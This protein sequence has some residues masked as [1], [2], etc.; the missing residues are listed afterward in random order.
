VYR[1]REKRRRRLVEIIEKFRQKGAISPEK[2]MSIQE[3]G[4]PPR[5]EEAIHGRLGSTGMFFEVNCKYYLDEEKL[6]RIREQRA[7]RGNGSI[8][9]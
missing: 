9:W 8:R 5:F 7:K 1:D 3:L 6:R 2:A 4:L